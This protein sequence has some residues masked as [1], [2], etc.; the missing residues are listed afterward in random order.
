MPLPSLLTGYFP[1]HLHCEIAGQDILALIMKAGSIHHFNEG[2]L[3]FAEAVEF[4]NFLNK[5][6]MFD[7]WLS[8]SVAYSFRSK[9]MQMFGC[10][11]DHTCVNG[12][13]Q[14]A[15]EKSQADMF[16]V[17]YFFQ[18]STQQQAMIQDKD[19]E[20]DV[21]VMA[22][23][24][25]FFNANILSFRETVV[26]GKFNSPYSMYSFWLEEHLADDRTAEEMQRFNWVESPITGDPN[27][28]WPPRY[29]ID[30]PMRC[31]CCGHR[32]YRVADALNVPK[33]RL[34][35]ANKMGKLLA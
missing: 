6:D 23:A 10:Q 30:D 9:E 28:P 19:I 29:G 16:P 25:H 31:H 13:L 35:P 33:G 3:N 11:D 7:F 4:G 20:L 17:A 22:G 21:L 8:C 26:Y 12:P 1:A 34:P 2:R 14:H 32:N 18:L 15:H 24:I 27:Q 5:D